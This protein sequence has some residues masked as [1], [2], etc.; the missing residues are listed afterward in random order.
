MKHYDSKGLIFRNQEYVHCKTVNLDYK[1]CN[2]FQLYVQ[3]LG[4]K[5]MRVGFLLGQFSEGGDVTVDAIYEP[6]Q[7][8]GKIVESE[9]QKK[10]SNKL[11]DC[12]GL[13]KV[14]WIFSHGERE[15][16]MSTEEI[17]IC[18]QYQSEAIDKYG[19]IAQSFVT[20][21]VAQEED[22]QSKI[23]AFQ[24]TDQTVKLY[25][26]KM[27][28]KSDDPLK[29]KVNAQVLMFKQGAGKQEDN[30]IDTDVLLKPVAV[31][32]DHKSALSADFPVEN[33][34]SHPQTKESLKEYCTKKAKLS[35]FL[36]FSDF[37]LLYFLL[38][39]L[40]INDNNELPA[41]CEAVKNGDEETTNGFLLIVK[42]LAGLHF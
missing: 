33:R 23:E 16:I 5:Q 35:S 12:L 22:G 24:V 9:E 32:A 37:H 26:N 29:V 39:H 18:A 10:K 38:S 31:K 8:N 41:L 4:F 3:S 17:E 28:V 14:G 25:K 36:L 7:K 11:I 21:K 42:S 34:G 15:F 13:A 6:P 40:D 30:Y 19:V 2:T 20:C 27:F 1:A